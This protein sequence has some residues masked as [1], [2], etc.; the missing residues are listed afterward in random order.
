MNSVLGESDLHFLFS[1]SA[2][3]SSCLPN[4]VIIT[5]LEIIASRAP[6]RDRFPAELAAIIREHALAVGSRSVT[7]R[8]EAAFDVIC[9]IWTPARFNRGSRTCTIST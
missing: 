8:F 1:Y 4:T 7:R 6:I 3:P 5:A 2:I 9:V